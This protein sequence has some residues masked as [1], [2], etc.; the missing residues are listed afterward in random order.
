MHSNN[1]PR[2]KKTSDTTGKE[3]FCLYPLS[4][5]SNHVSAVILLLLEFPTQDCVYP[6]RLAFTLHK[7]MI[8]LRNIINAAYCVLILP[9]SFFADLDSGQELGANSQD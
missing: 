6:M 5:K 8:L 9:L 4:K 7:W 3:S 2:K 1:R